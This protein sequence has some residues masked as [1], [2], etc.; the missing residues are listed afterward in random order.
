MVSNLD[1]LYEG[2]NDG[3]NTTSRSHMSLCLFAVAAAGIPEKRKDHALV[4]ARF[5]HACMQA[6]SRQMKLLEKTLGPDTGDLTIRV[7]LHSGSVTAGIL[8]G[9]RARMQLFGDTMNMGSRM[10]SS[11]QPGRIHVSEDTA[12]L[13]EASGKSH[14]LIAS[15]EKADIK[16]KGLVQTY[17]LNV[18]VDGLA[19]TADSSSNGETRSES[20]EHDNKAKIEEKLE[21]L[22]DWNVD[23]FSG[24]LKQIAA[25]RL[26]KEQAKGES[27]PKK[28]DVESLDDLRFEQISDEVSCLDEVKDI[29][30]LPKYDRKIAK[31]LQDPES[32]KLHQTVTDELREYIRA[33][34]LM[35]RENAFHNFGT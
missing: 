28:G 17:W 3:P 23:V 33:I 1:K 16:G 8:R 15:E 11:G 26:A 10:E 35:Y 13:L 30:T 2:V 27:R 18:T 12:H 9:Q 22:I 29:I 4:M 6:T 24:L 25:H 21:R 34:A 19:S 5:A 20:F 14:W 31:F 32:I 7:G